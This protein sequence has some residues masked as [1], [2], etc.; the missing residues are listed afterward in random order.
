MCVVEVARE[1]KERNYSGEF[2][3]DEE[4]RY[5]CDGRVSKGICVFVEEFGE[6]TVEALDARL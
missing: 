3:E 5:V 1:A 4:G 2:V 6:S